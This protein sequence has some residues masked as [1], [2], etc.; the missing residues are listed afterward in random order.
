M[1]CEANKTHT[2]SGSEACLQFTYSPNHISLP[3]DFLKQTS[4]SEEMI[5]DSE[6]LHRNYL[7]IQENSTVFSTEFFFIFR[8]EIASVTE[9]T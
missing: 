2:F 9:H 5:N 6:N 3:R 4:L 7:L 1:M 8:T